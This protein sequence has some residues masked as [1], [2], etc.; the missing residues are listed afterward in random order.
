MENNGQNRETP[1]DEA[2]RPTN[3]Q[4]RC[5][6]CGAQ[7][8]ARTR[9]DHGFLLWCAHHYR[10]HADGLSDHLVYYRTASETPAAATASA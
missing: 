1:M 7:A 8:F 5:D 9:H 2:Q 10:E 6:R 3:A 4:D